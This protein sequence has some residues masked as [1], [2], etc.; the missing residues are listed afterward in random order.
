M[1]HVILNHLAVLT[2]PSY[3]CHNRVL[4]DAVSSFLFALTPHAVPARLYVFAN[5]LGTVCV[6]NRTRCSSVSPLYVCHF[7]HICWSMLICAGVV[8]LCLHL[9]VCHYVCASVSSAP[10]ADTLI[11]DESIALPPMLAKPSLSISNESSKVG[12]HHILQL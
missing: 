3:R 8:S 6:A 4:P 1:H 11:S 7:V 2:A 9:C 12:W 5:P 10:P